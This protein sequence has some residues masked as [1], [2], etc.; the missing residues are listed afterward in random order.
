M[1]KDYI[2]RFWGAHRSYRFQTQPDELESEDDIQSSGFQSEEDLELFEDWMIHVH[3]HAYNSGL[4]E[5]SIRGSIGINI[6]NH[7][8]LF[9]LHKHRTEIL[10]F[11][12]AICQYEGELKKNI[13][14][15]P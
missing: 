13:S 14:F 1:S 15:Y 7:E 4:S 6:W 2:D 8:Q 5:E 12:E 3:H 10:K 9:Y 11:L